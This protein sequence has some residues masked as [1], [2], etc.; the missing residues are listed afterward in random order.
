MQE[1]LENVRFLEFVKA[2]LFISGI[3]CVAVA[4]PLSIRFGPGLIISGAK[5]MYDAVSAM[6]KDSTEREIRLRELKQIEKRA[7][8]ASTH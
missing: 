5:S 7:E 8:T 6:L 4:T 1:L 2:A 3:F